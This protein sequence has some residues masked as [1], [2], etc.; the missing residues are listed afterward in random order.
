M[1]S[2]GKRCRGLD[3]AAQIGGV[4]VRDAGVVQP[5]GEPDAARRPPPTT[6]NRPT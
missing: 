2:A 4:N 5:G 6:A 1:A 3:R